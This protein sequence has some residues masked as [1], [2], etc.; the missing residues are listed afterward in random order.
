MPLLHRQQPLKLSY[1]QA[2]SNNLSHQ[3]PIMKDS[4][5]KAF[6]TTRLRSFV[7]EVKNIDS[8]GNYVQ[9]PQEF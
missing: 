2:V 3:W 9:S 4:L 5:N 1:P 6:C 7:L 8:Q